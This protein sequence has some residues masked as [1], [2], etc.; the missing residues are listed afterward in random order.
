PMGGRVCGPT[1][2]A[3]FAQG[4]PR[5]GGAGWCLLLCVSVASLLAFGCR[6][7]MHDQPRYEPYEKSEF[8]TDGRAMRPQVEGTV[9]RGQLQED[10]RLFT[11]KEGTAFVASIP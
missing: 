3:R 1:A 8:F 10:A 4:E 11:G 2:G 7:D 5:P 6:Q 9:A